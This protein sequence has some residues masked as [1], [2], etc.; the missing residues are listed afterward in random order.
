MNHWRRTDHLEP[1]RSERMTEREDT[2]ASV[3]ENEEG[4]CAR[5]LEPIGEC[6]IGGNPNGTDATEFFPYWR[7][8]HGHGSRPGPAWGEY[9]DI[10]CDGCHE[11]LTAPL[12]PIPDRIVGEPEDWQPV[13]GGWM[14]VHTRATDRV[15]FGPFATLKELDEWMRDIGIPRGVSGSIVPLVSPSSDPANLWQDPVI[16]GQIKIVQPEKVDTNA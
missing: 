7:D 12:P 5:C 16:E 13:V 9:Y 14:I 4:E 1:I 8:V 11:V 3:L 15:F 6:W 2:L 10:F